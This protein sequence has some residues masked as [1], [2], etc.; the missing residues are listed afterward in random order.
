M[1]NKIIAPSKWISPYNSIQKELRYHLKKELFRHNGV[2]YAKQLAPLLNFFTNSSDPKHKPWKNIN[3]LKQALFK[4]N[5]GKLEWRCEIVSLQILANKLEIK[6]E[7]IPIEFI[8]SFIYSKKPE[9]Q[10]KYPFLV[11]SG[12]Q[13]SLTNNGNSDHPV[14][15]FN[16]FLRPINTFRSNGLA[17]PD[18][19]FSR[20]EIIFG[21]HFDLDKTSLSIKDNF[22]N[23]LRLW[24]CGDEKSKEVDGL[25]YLDVF[26]KKVLLDD[27][28]NKALFMLFI[29]RKE[30][31]LLVETILE[32]TNDA[33][34]DWFAAK[35]N[36][37]LFSSEDMR[38]E[39]E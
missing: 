10:T 32:C 27:L 33:I 28:S 12:R 16:I 34:R 2:I 1:S 3:H 14:F 13:Q 22:D 24:V 5:E 6:E 31:A 36:N 11:Y 18:A 9:N 17:R 23:E 15:D 19:H 39:K 30:Y 7:Q 4:H 35:N 26:I 25:K 8:N 37:L 29:N 20:K 38:Y 21:M